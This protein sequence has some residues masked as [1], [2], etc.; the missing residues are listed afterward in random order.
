MEITY[1]DQTT[2][3]PSESRHVINPEGTIGYFFGGWIDSTLCNTLY[4][5]HFEIGRV[6]IVSQG[7]LMG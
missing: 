2:V 3:V 4:S 5:L 1:L 7:K 6:E